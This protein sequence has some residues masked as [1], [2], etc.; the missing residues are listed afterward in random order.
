MF[1]NLRKSK[2]PEEEGNPALTDNVRKKGQKRK[3]ED[4][5]ELVQQISSLEGLVNQRTRD[6]EQAKNQLHQLYKSPG[7]AEDVAVGPGEVLPDAALLA[8]P[9]KTGKSSSPESEEERLKLAESLLENVRG[10][11]PVAPPPGPPEEAAEKPKEKPAPVAEKPDEPAADDFF[12]AVE[13]EENALSSLIASMPDVNID[14]LLRTA[15]E[16]KALAQDF[17]PEENES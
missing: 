16:V 5:D 14:E 3:D 9:E 6:L 12:T 11:E 13:E 10:G 15:E 2:G 8:E 7:G 17:L 1:L 4:S